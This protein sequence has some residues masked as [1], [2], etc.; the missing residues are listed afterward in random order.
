MEHP[1]PSHSGDTT[2]DEE[3]SI[4]EVKASLDHPLLLHFFHSTNSRGKVEANLPPNNPR[5]LPHSPP[6]TTLHHPV[7]PP[8]ASPIGAQPHT[9]R[10]R[11]DGAL[12]HR[13][14]LTSR[15]RSGADMAQCES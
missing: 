11:S 8:L 4:I 14:L 5:P 3:E 12:P 6:Q 9:Q 1:N 7:L 2:D 15:V 13:P 10:S